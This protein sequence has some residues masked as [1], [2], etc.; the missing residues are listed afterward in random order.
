MQQF[1]SRQPYVLTLVLLSVFVWCQLSNAE[2]QS[3]SNPTTVV[4]NIGGKTVLIKDLNF[5]A[6]YGVADGAADIVYTGQTGTWTFVLSAVG[7]NAA[8]YSSAKAII[9][10]VLDDHYDTSTT[11]YSMKIGVPSGT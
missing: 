6:N 1:Y 10:L 11:L 4:T 2:L 9:T 5:D 7:L 8:N 3:T